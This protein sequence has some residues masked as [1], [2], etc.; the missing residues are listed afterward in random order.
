METIDIYG[1]TEGAEKVIISN[2]RNLQAH[3]LL[4]DPTHQFLGLCTLLS[5]VSFYP[6]RITDA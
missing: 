5:S 4:T 2:V 3:P 6:Q 1:V